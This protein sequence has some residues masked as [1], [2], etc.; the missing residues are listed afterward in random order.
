M[1]PAGLVQNRVLLMLQSFHAWFVS[2]GGE[3]RADKNSPPP[4]FLTEHFH[5]L[6]RTFLPGRQT[7]KTPS[8]KDVL[9]FV[10]RVTHMRVSQGTVFSNVSFCHLDI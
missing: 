5:C 9:S 4:L 2:E 6:P 1:L 3:A 10:A 8:Q 7:V